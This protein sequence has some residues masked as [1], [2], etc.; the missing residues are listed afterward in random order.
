MKIR[1]Q[2]WLWS[3]GIVSIGCVYTNVEEETG[4][5]SRSKMDQVSPKHWYPSIKSGRWEER[6]ILRHVMALQK[7]MRKFN[8]G[9]GSQ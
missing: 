6:P 7:P 3:S 5:L 2:A 1:N 9:K 4:A 8:R